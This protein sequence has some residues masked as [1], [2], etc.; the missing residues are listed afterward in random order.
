MQYETLFFPKWMFGNSTMKHLYKDLTGIVLSNSKVTILVDVFHV[1][2]LAS[3]CCLACKA[4]AI[5]A[6]NYAGPL[7]GYQRAE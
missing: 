6:H 4:V 3:F 7:L 2:S 5:S 1:I